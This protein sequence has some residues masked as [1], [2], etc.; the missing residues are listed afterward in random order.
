MMRE[1]NLSMAVFIAFIW[2]SPAWPI[3]QRCAR[4]ARNLRDAAETYE[5]ALSDLESAKSSYESACNS[6]YGYS[7]SDK[8]ACGS[9][10]YERSDYE[11]ALDDFRSAVDELRNA[12]DNVIRRCEPPDYRPNSAAEICYSQLIETKKELTACMLKTK[13]LKAE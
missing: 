8:S 9:Y 6:D 11:S 13:D 3:D 1:V 12:Y 4:E 5:T 2:A 7:A 10:G